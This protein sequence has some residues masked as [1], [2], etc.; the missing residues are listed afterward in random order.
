MNPSWCR[1]DDHVPFTRGAKRGPRRPTCSLPYHG[2]QQFYCFVL[3]QLDGSLP[4]VIDLFENRIFSFKV[5]HCEG[6]NV[7]WMFKFF[8]VS[9]RFSFWNFR[10]VYVRPSLCL[11]SDSFVKTTERCSVKGPFFMRN[12]PR[13]VLL[14]YITVN[15]R[16]Q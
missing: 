13:C 4:A 10:F 11:L 3:W 16:L 8:A 12:V 5:S 9:L 7:F 15:V 2:K 1:E 6:G 14:F